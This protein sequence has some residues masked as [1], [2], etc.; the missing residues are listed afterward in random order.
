MSQYLF[1]KE[2]VSGLVRYLAARPY[3]EVAALLERIN[4]EAAAQSK[5]QQPEAV[6]QAKEAS[7]EQAAE[8]AKS[9]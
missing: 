7:D 6:P 3:Q 1:S 2:L 4:E 9:A 8:E 5:P